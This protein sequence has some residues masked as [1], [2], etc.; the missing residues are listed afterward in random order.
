MPCL[1]SFSGSQ[2]LH[3]MW[4][5]SH[6]SGIVQHHFYGQLVHKCQYIWDFVRTYDMDR[7]IVSMPLKWK[8]SASSAE[9]SPPISPPSPPTPPVIIEKC[10]PSTQHPPAVDT[11]G[12]QPRLSFSAQQ[13]NGTL[14]WPCDFYVCNIIK[15][16][17]NCKTS[18]KWG[19]KTIQTVQVVFTEHFPDIPFKSSTYH[20]HCSIWHNAPEHLKRQ[21][22]EAGHMK[23]GRWAAFTNA[24]QQHKMASKV[25]ELSD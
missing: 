11:D 6:I 10:H 19:S 8:A 22:C 21:F 1:M 9:P 15:C 20:D 18:V 12:N 7:D 3:A 16:F 14:E 17:T 25:I 5:M 13:L 2:V 24:I 4:L 23:K